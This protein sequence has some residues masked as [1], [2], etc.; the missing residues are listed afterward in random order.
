[1]SEI[2]D[3]SEAW[4]ELGLSASI[5][6][7]ERAAVDQCIVKAEGAVKRHL[8]YDPVSRR[9]TEYYPGHDL[10]LGR[11]ASIYEVSST[12]AY[13]RQESSGQTSELQ[14]RH[15]PIRA[16]PAMEVRVDYDGRSGTRAGAFAAETIQTEGEDFW[17]NYDQ[18]DG[19]D[20]RI[21]SDG[22]LRS[23]GAWPL[24]AGT[25]RVAY[26]AGYT[27]IELHG[28]DE[29]DVAGNNILDASPIW[30]A[31]LEE[32]KRRFEQIM[33]RK[34]SSAGGW[35]AGP[36]T[37]ESLGD[38]SYTIDS[39]SAKALYGGTVELTNDSKM[40][41]QPFVHMGWDV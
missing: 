1:M 6:E 28:Q 29:P 41:L 20:V 39:S 23:Q 40:L 30:A 33:V 35:A 38:Y 15:I 11:V 19:R 31:I 5:T 3:P 14:L 10:S 32:T 4:L 24:T 17:A 25:V 18:F 26:T 16:T 7:E 27:N 13:I 36:K 37:S 8:R 22:L 9:R 12:Q 34:K 21:C 2:V